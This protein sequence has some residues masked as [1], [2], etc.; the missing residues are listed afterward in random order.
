MDYDEKI[1]IVQAD[2]KG[3]LY[4]GDDHGVMDCAVDLR[5]LKAEKRG[6]ER[7]YE[8]ARKDLQDIQDV[9]GQ[10]DDKPPPVVSGGMPYGSFDPLA[11]LFEPT[12]ILD[13]SE[14]PSEPCYK[15]SLCKL[16]GMHEGPCDP[17]IPV[18][19]APAHRKKGICWCGK[20]HGKNPIMYG[21]YVHIPIPDAPPIP[22]P[23]D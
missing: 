2:Q 13:S 1:A 16:P 7:G 12:V 17:P 18:P 4:R 14:L 22:G 10:I 3:K 9:L 8:Q 5:E 15:Y 11:P 20:N 6:F 23:R 21:Q 19:S